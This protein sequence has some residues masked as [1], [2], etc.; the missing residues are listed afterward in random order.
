MATILIVDDDQAIITALKLLLKNEGHQIESACSPEQALQLVKRTSVDIALLDMNYTGDTT[1]GEEGLELIR[2][3]QYLCPDL[4]AVAMTGWSSV[5]L[6]VQCLQA[7][8]NDFIEK[9]WDNK[10]LLSIVRNQEKLC[11]QKNTQEKLQ[12]ENDLLY[13]ELART[14]NHKF[15]ANSA[16]MQSLLDTV[17]KIADSDLSVFIAGENGT[18]KGV[19]ARY[20]HQ[21]SQRKDGRMVAVNTGAISDSLFESELFGHVK[22]SFT[23]AKQTRIGRFELADKGTLFLDEIGNLPLS[24][25]AKLLRVLEEKRFEKVGSSC[26]QST[27]VRIIS[28]TNANLMEMVEC[29][30]FRQDLLYRL[31]GVELRMPALRERREDIAPLAQQM[32]QEACANKRHK[33]K[34]SAAALE[35]LERYDWPGNVR[36]LAHVIERSVILCAGATISE[37]ELMLKQ[38]VPYEPAAGTGNTLNASLEDIEKQAIEQRISYHKG[39]MT[40]AAR[41]LGLSRSAFYRRL[42]K[43]KIK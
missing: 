11:L 13:R 39:N 30:T 26:T 33:P 18:G 9:P 10:R 34:L 15:I 32:L 29:G 2:K 17:H 4:A 40:E 8:A 19:L 35:S 16:L 41:S 25:Q 23:D 6:A 43:L 24:Q 38:S 21:C 37:G 36:E 20:I 28:A 1:S 42:E 14:N 12:S 22:G 27:D 7:G 31:N 5:D 3:F